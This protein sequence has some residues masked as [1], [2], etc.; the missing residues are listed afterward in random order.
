MKHPKLEQIMQ[1]LC[2]N[3]LAT[4]QNQLIAVILFGSQA[5]GD[6]TPDSDFVL[7]IKIIDKYLFCFSFFCLHK[8]LEL[9]LCQSFPSAVQLV[10]FERNNS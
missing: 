4:Y 10:I 2:D 6:A 5:R 8:D 3:L 9:T 1:E 7:L